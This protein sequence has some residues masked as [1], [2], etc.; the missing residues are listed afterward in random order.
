MI[1]LALPYN[2][3]T[4]W[5]VCSLNLATELCQL[6]KIK[7]YSDELEND[8][9]VNSIA[10]RF[11][12]KISFKDLNYIK[13]QK[14]YPLIQALEHDL[15]PYID[16]FNGS[17]KIGITFADRKI[18]REMVEKSKN[19]D[20]IISGSTWSQNLLQQNKVNSI[21]IHQ[22]INPIIFNESRKQKK[23]FHDDFILFSGCKYETR[24]GQDVVIKAFK[25]ICEKYPDVRLVCNWMN[26]YTQK[27]GR[28]D[29]I[30]AGIS[31]DRVI[32]TPLHTHEI[33]AEIYQ[34]TDL[35]IFPSRCEAG[36]NL[37]MME[38][39][40]CGKPCIATT[41]TGQGDILNIENGLPL[42][43]KGETVLRSPEGDFLSNWEEPDV[44]HLVDLI[45]WSY[46][47]RKKIEKL[48]KKAA[49]TMK[50][51]TWSNMAKEMI[52]LIYQ[53]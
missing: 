29:L 34:N 40:A 45:E 44:E 13:N 21:V 3:Y 12:K 28:E 18:P 47:N 31:H 7:Y 10:D 42:R 26:T 6:T 48:G 51:K 19:Y 17:I 14:D 2:N 16:Y 22:G 37:V 9:S 50:N 52:K 11:F 8:K 4:G 15:K 36:T 41:G 1:F 27:D 30:N 24:K 46:K 5:G 39:M 23:Y 25:I 38:Y 49:S 53:P 43:S 32:M 33:M 35:G 20:F